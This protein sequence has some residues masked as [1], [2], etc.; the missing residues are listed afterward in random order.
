M[1]QER[2]EAN[3]GESYFGGD[4]DDYDAIKSA[5]SA[6]PDGDRNDNTD[7]YDTEA[8]DGDLNGDWETLYNLSLAQ[9]TSPTQELSLIHI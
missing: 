5:G 3:F 8:T 6:G 4:E 9:R 1:T 7:R 2:A